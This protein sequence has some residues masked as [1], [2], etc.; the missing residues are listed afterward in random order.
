MDNSRRKILVFDD[1]ELVGDI[2]CRMLTHFEC[3]A[4]HVFTFSDAL[5]EYQ[6]RLATPDAFTAVLAD[7]NVPGGQG[8]CE[9]AESLLV[10]DPHAQ[11][12]ATSGNS[13][14][15]AMQRPKDFG[16]LGKVSKP[17]DLTVIK[18]FIVQI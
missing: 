1:E 12:F 17:I 5:K 11:I 9:L 2:V 18:E 4:V 13:M 10:L 8:G 16:F 6:E 15:D 14:E 3:D 7:L